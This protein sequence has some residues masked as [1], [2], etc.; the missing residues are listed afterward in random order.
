[1]NGSEEFEKGADTMRRLWGET[2]YGG[3][4][5][6]VDPDSWKMHMEH[7]FGELMSRPGL[8][9]RDRAL[10]NLAINTIIA[11]DYKTQLNAK[12]WLR[13]NIHSAIN[14]GI[15]KEEILETFMHLAH[16]AGWPAAINALLVAKAVFA[17][18]HLKEKKNTPKRLNEDQPI[19]IS[20]RTKKGKDLLQQLNGCEVQG[21]FMEELFPEFWEMTIGHLF[22]EVWSRPGLALR[23]RIIVSMVAHMALRFNFG[24]EKSMRWALNNGISREEILEMIMHVAHFRG[25]PFGM[26]ALMVARSVFPSKK[27]P[28]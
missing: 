21:E 3:F 18:E 12:A 15:S 26:N 13:S 1:M 5:T 14:N 2:S 10:I 23:D 8:A 4:V 25:W 27:Q 17:P 7:F 11:I 9:L 19:S 22:G 28:G 24:L 6:E 16:Y 20:E